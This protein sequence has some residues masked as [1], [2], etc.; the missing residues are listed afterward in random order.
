MSEGFEAVMENMTPE[1]ADACARLLL[2]ELEGQT[3]VGEALPDQEDEADTLHGLTEAAA[4]LCVRLERAE[5]AAVRI[6]MHPP[7]LCG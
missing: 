7:E 2:R 3:P 1:Q 4:E 5:Q 6:A